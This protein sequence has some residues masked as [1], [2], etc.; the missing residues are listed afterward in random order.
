MKRILL[1]KTEMFVKSGHRKNREY[2]RL[3]KLLAILTHIAL[4]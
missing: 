1:S 3:V 2:L 4:H